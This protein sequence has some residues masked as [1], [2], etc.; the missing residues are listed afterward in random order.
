MTRVRGQ[1]QQ[2]MMASGARCV[3]VANQI[4]HSPFVDP[5]RPYCW[6]AGSARLEPL[7]LEAAAL[8][9]DDVDEL[10]DVVV[11]QLLEDLD[12]PRH[13]GRQLAVRLEQQLLHR[14]APLGHAVI[15]AE[16][17]PVGPRGNAWSSQSI[18]PGRL[19]A[20]SDKTKYKSSHAPVRPL[21]DR[22]RPL[23][24]ADGPC[25]P[26][27]GAGRRSRRVP[28]AP[29]AGAHHPPPSMGSAPD[30][31]VRSEGAGLVGRRGPSQPVVDEA[32]KARPIPLLACPCAWRVC[33]MMRECWR[34]KPT[35]A[36]PLSS[37][38]SFGRE[39][40]WLRQ[41]DAHHA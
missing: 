7:T 30:G 5:P 26:R 31:Q 21:P 23:K 40:H 41:Y 6:L 19:V 1:P 28:P 3:R 4:N 36:D 13:G 20:A 24:V 22:L 29:G 25:A 39:M 11:A 37:V 34:G 33:G 38:L 9:G 18:T 15:A 10:D 35:E 12:L 2:Q 32:A 16:D 8:G 27:G 17:A 14:H